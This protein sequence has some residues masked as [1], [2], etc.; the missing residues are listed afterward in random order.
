M[1]AKHG[2]KNLNSHFVQ[3]NTQNKDEKSN[4]K[5]ISLLRRE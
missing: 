2:E 3:V 5:K 4:G 1:N